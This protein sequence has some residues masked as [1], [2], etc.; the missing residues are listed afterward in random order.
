MV[1]DEQV[2][3]LRCKRMEGKTQETAA[4]LAGMCERTARKWE[5]GPLPSVVKEQRSRHWRTRKDPFAEVWDEDVVPML[6]ADEKGE[7][8]VKTV[9]EMLEEK[10][11]G[12]FQPG[13]TAT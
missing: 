3:V 4:A 1:T 8:Q 7:L 9:F 2:K 5:T 11:P 13:L 6:A 12:R 10:Y